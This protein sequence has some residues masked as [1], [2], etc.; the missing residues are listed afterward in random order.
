MAA[1]MKNVC[2]IGETYVN[3]IQ[4]FI[5]GKGYGKVMLKAICQKWPDVWWM[6]DYHADDELLEYYRSLPFVSEHSWTSPRGLKLHIFYQ[7]ADT[8]SEQKINDGAEASFA[9]PETFHW[10]D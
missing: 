7:A 5:S 1:L 4:T 10:S 8:E 3:E 6:K 9:G 2:G